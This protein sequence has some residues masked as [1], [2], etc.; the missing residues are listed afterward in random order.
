MALSNTDAVLVLTTIPA[1]LDAEALVRP[2]LERRLV[3]CANLLPAMRSIYGWRGAIESAEERQVVFKTRRA[4]VT[5]LEAALAA[6][7][8]YEVPEFLVVPVSGG[9]EAYL[10][11]VSGETVA[12]EA[13]GN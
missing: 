11:W 1:G 5:A 3:A 6:V 8:P 9:G 4:C 12:P 13:H 2:L 10:A 7:H